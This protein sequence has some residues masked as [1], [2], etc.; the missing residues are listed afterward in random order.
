ML[1]DGPLPH[2][3][4]GRSLLRTWERDFLLILLAVGAG[5][6]DGWSYLGLGHAF[7]ANMTGNTVMVGLAVFTGHDLG[8]RLTALLC[9]LPGAALGALLTRGARKDVLWPQAVSWTLLLEGALIAGAEAGWSALHHGAARRALPVPVLLGIVAFAIGMQSGAM[10]QLQ[11]PGIVTTYISGTWTLLMTGIATFGTREAC[12]PQGERRRFEER[13][14]MQGG[15]VTAYLG[16]AVLA[17]WL[18]QWAPGAIGL[19]PA[20]AVLLVAAYGLARG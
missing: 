11:I 10:L 20:S 14:L 8:P 13:L 7:V 18:G 9:Y 19:A 1:A 15:I 6:A 12:K 2:L 4:N 16:A 5:S 17:G 3:S